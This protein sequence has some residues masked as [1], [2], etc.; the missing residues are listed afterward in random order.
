MVGNFFWLVSVFFLKLSRVFGGRREKL[1]E[2]WFKEDGDHRYLL[3]HPSLGENSV[4]FEPV[5]DFCKIISERFGRNKNI[6]IFNFG[7]VGSPSREVIDRRK[8]ACGCFW[9]KKLN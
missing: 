4:V 6:K 1:V 3:N 5:D 8:Y 9:F 2:I 7:L